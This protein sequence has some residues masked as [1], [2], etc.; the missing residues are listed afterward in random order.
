MKK[1]RAWPLVIMTLV[2]AVAV[3]AL[4]AALE[5]SK[6]RLKAPPANVAADAAIPATPTA[7]ATAESTRT[8][9]DSGK[10]RP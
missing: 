1:V 3:Y 8:R 9:R 10:R 6:P 2:A 7:S 4:I 5:T